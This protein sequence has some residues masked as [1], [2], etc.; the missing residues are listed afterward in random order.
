METGRKLVILAYHRVLSK[1]DNL[2]PDHTGA[3]QFRRHMSTLSRFFNV[4]TVS[5]GLRKLRSG[6]LP[7]RAV[8]VSFDDGYQDNFSVALPILRQ[9]NLPA[10]F[11]VATGFIDGGRMWNDTIIET[12]RRIDREKLDATDW[13]L[14]HLRTATLEDR[15]AAAATLISELKYRDR[16][17]RERQVLE[18][19]H[20]AGVDLPSGLMMQRSEVKALYD[21]GMEI[22]AH[23]VNHPIL[24]RTDI[25][26]ATNEIMRSREWLETLTG[27]PITSFAYPNGRPGEDYTDEHAHIVRRCGFENAVSTARGVANYSSDVFQL[28][29]IGVWDKSAAKFGLRMMLLSYGVRS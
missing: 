6:D 16:N 22:G 26:D 17:T 15:R 19:A 12:V 3:A 18:I 23:T 2:V 8:A 7:A 29:R 9:F 27:A 24:A 20:A 10:T 13:G 14:G 11:Y 4:V 25:D 5:D 1:P 21:A 28:P